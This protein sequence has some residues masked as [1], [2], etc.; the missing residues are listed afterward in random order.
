MIDLSH[1]QVKLSCFVSNL[2]MA[3]LA[4]NYFQF[5]LFPDCPPC[6][7]GNFDISY[8]TQY[9][10]KNIFTEYNISTDK[11][12]LSVHFTIFVI[13]ISHFLLQDFPIFQF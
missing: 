3:A 9:S 10:S 6:F 8:M 7:S 4:P 13:S 1:I 2:V 11:N 12:I 5:S